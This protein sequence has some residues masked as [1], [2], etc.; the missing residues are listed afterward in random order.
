M[1]IYVIKGNGESVL[2]DPEKLKQALRNAGAGTEDQ[3]RITNQ[4]SAKLY[5]GIPTR[6]I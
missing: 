4:V 6:K 5:N 1:S 3:R 2:F